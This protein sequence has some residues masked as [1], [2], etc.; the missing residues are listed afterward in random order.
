MP[1]DDDGDIVMLSC[2]IQWTRMIC[3]RTLLSGACAAAAASV[4]VLRV[5]FAVYHSNNIF[6]EFWI[7]TQNSSQN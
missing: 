5:C 1:C 3:S 2:H 4:V 7:E 6:P